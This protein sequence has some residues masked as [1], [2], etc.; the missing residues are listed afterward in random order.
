MTT[1]TSVNG[2]IVLLLAHIAGMID[3]V[4]LPVWVGAALIGQYKFSPQQAGGMVT[5]YLLGAVLASAFF[6]SRFTRFSAR[7]YST[8]GYA[9]SCLAFLGLTQT[10][11]L[12]AMMVLHAIAGL[13]AGTGLSFTH[14]TIGRSANPHRLFATVGL[15]LCISA[16]LFLG[17]SQSLIP[18]S[19]GTALFAMFAA[20]MAVAAVACVLGFPALDNIAA[21]SS[22][23]KGSL[24]APAWLVIFGV[25]C[26]ALNQAMLFS[27]VE[28]IGA[29]RGYGDKVTGVLIA[30]GFINLIP[31]ILAGVL[32]NRLPARSVLIAG[33]I[34]QAILASLIIF[35]SEF[36]VY[37]FAASIFVAVMIFTHTF[38][39]GVLTQLDPSGRAA[40][41][42]AATLMLG[43]AIGPILG[44]VLIQQ[45]GYPALGIA[46]V[47]VSAIAVVFFARACS[48]LQ[49]PATVMQKI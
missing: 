15:G 46:V 33:P 24:S 45:V 16:I 28:R 48:G 32:Q 30:L 41:A 37:A 38:A 31:P 12:S 19:N 40:A 26:M 22:G 10:R 17:S 14:G 3:M 49:S 43:A 7:L 42:T 1:T 2:R 13:A 5:L 11:D 27:F 39:F 47:L 18:Q 21:N 25:I 36:S 4:A 23:A 6:A 9:V 44:G 29:D 8:V 20:I 34:A 35:T